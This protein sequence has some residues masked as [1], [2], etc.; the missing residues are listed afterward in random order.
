M[1]SVEAW[2]PLYVADYLK[3]TRHLSTEE[4]G[5]YLL[6]LMTAWTSDGALPADDDR[7]RRLTGMDPKNWK[8]SRG[9]LLEFFTRDGDT[10]RHKRVDAELA[11]AAEHAERRSSKARAAAEARWGQSPKD[12]PS[13]APSSAASNAPSM[14]GGCPPPSP[15]PEEE[16]E[17]SIFSS[18]SLDLREDDAASDA[19]SIAHSLCRT[20]GVSVSS[21][22]AIATAAQLVRDWQQA[23]ATP[24]LMTRVIAD[25]LPR[26]AEPVHSLRYFNARVLNAIALEAQGHDPLARNSSTGNARSRGGA[27]GFARMVAASMGS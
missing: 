9:V 11:A 12:A 19:V 26:A 22:K 24:D 23:G 2:M 18:S 13:N 17:G 20:A 15:S 21:P 10:W 8:A 4:H 6:L 5:A 16:K 7:L 25:A 3:D 27:G 14:L 1:K